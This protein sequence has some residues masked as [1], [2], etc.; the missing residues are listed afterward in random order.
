MNIDNS[1]YDPKKD[2]IWDGPYIDIEQWRKEPVEHLYIH[3]GFEGTNTRFSFYFPHKDRYQGRFF[4][5]LTPVQGSEDAS[6]GRVGDEDNIG[7]AVEHNSYFV[8]SNMNGQ[9][10]DATMLFKSSA[11]V[12]E[13]SR[14]VARRLFGEHRPFGYVFGGSG[15]GYK[16][17]AC[18]ERTEGIWDGSVPFVIGCPMSIPNMFTVRVH[19]TRILRHKLDKIIDAV[20]PGG[21]G[22]MYDGLND[23]EAAALTELLKMGFNPR[24]LFAHEEI[25]DGALPVLTY[26]IDMMDSEYYKDFWELPGYLGADINGS[27]RRDR[28]QFET[29]VKGVLLP[30][31]EFKSD[32]LG[33]DS[34]WQT[35]A[36]K[37]KKDP[38]IILE[39]VPD[40]I[41]YIKGTKIIIKSGAAAGLKLP[42]GKL[43]QN[44]A[45]VGMAFGMGDVA[46]LMQDIKPGDEV[47][48][49]NSDYIAIQTYHRHQV[50]GD[51]Y[52]AWDQFRDEN[53]EPIYPQRKELLGPIVAF[54]GAGSVQS[55]KMH[56]KMIVCAS[57][58]DEAALAWQADWYKERI[59]KAG[60]IEDFRL[61]YNDNVFHGGIDEYSKEAS[62]IITSYRAMIIKALLDV[63]A[64]AEKGIEPAQS[65]AYKIVDSQVIVPEDANERKG[66]QS[67]VSF[68]ADGKVKAEAAAG[69][70]VVFESIITAPE[71]TGIIE[72]AEIDFEGSCEYAVKAELT[73]L[74]EDSTKAKVRLTHKFL[75]P[76][77]Y[78][79]VI[80][81]YSNSRPGDLYTQVKNLARVRVIVK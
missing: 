70:E 77:T 65:T 16:T 69:Q 23:E 71:G 9:D 20:Q 41:S 61:W 3:G 6:Q 31:D 64:W 75:E 27:A 78:L 26:A 37:Y 53:G 44:A 30:T 66:I 59:R 49:D 24:S 32:K 4:Q 1:I 79:P 39:K 40:N 67:T 54:T 63:S 33:V 80:K 15:G 19:A 38:A 45:V 62:C 18:V 34:A 2:S 43:D 29:K 76:G 81:A 50:P 8:E 21:S 68:T 5:Q 52:C 17:I 28:L 57:I 7:F 22:D 35:L 51:E 74:N 73:M 58:M 72:G 13:Y 12:A 55:G 25:G 56:G 46:K 48:L 60:R 14:E 47:V 11:A 42:L 10:E 36:Y